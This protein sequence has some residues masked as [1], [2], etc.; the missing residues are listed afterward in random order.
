[1]RLGTVAEVVERIVGGRRRRCSAMSS[2]IG[3]AP[4]R[5]RS[6]VARRDRDDRRAEGVAGRA[7]IR[8]SVRSIM[9]W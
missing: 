3:A 1:M 8:R 9:A 4:G 2:S 6:T 5:A 7:T